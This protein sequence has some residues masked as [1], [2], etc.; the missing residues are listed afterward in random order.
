MKC[1]IQAEIGIDGSLHTQL[2]PLEGEAAFSRVVV[3]ALQ[4]Q[5]GAVIHAGA[6]R[7]DLEIGA[8]VCE[9][10]ANR[11]RVLSLKRRGEEDCCGQQQDNLIRAATIY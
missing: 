2:E 6:A 3:S 1:G 9:T 8:E 7:G 4:V 5:K 10:Q 11:P